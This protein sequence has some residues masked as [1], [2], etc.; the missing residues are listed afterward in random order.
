MHM[1]TGVLLALAGLNSR[2]IA[3]RSI[4]ESSNYVIDIEEKGFL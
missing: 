3:E 2:T 4:L 1:L